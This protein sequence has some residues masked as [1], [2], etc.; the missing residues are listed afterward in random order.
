MSRPRKPEKSEI[1]SIRAPRAVADFL[2][3]LDAR[4]D[5]VLQKIRESAEYLEYERQRRERENAQT[6]SLPLEF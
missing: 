1:F 5:F 4:N 6:P 2:K 3:S